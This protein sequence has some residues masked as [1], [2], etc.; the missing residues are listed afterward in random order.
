MN[1]DWFKKELEN[2]LGSYEIN[3]SSFENGDFGNLNRVEF[4]G[5][6]KGGNID[7]WDSGWMEIHL[8]DYKEEKQLFHVML[9]PNQEYEKERAIEILKG[10]LIN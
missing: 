3:F 10:F 1:L 8:V 2:K 7:F 4:E 6:G 5:L 9:E